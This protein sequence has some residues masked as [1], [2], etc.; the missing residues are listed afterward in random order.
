MEMFADEVGFNLDTDLMPL[1]TGDYAL[2]VFP[3]NE[4]VI[5]S[6]AYVDLGGMA[7][8]TTSDGDKISEYASN[9]EDALLN[10]YTDVEKD[11]SPYD[12][13][14]VM[15]YYTGTPTLGY[16]V[17]DNYLVISTSV[18]D[19]ADVFDRSSSLKDS[20]NYTTA[21]AAFGSG[22]TPTIYVN[23]ADGLD[24][25]G[26]AMYY[27]DPSS[28][29]VLRPIQSIVGGVSKMQNNITHSRILIVIEKDF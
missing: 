24:Y 13:W 19:M 28:L 7:I 29:D 18:D 2:G 11:S 5:A 1:M 17:K 4:G 3:S 21:I 16:G 10:S 25:I 27:Y 26:D 22:L 6:S 12:I 8:F 14:S 15:D 20:E 9:V 23:F